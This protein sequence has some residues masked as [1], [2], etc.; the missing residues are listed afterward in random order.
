MVNFG[1]TASCR[2][3]EYLEDITSLLTI[4]KKIQLSIWFSAD[5]A[6]AGFGTLSIGAGLGTAGAGADF[7][8]LGASAGYRHLKCRLTDI[9]T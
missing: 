2:K 4:V 7:G 9:G 5:A 6:S 8:T 1:V 3:W